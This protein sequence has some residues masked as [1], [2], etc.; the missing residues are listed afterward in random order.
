MRNLRNIVLASGGVILVTV[1]IIIAVI[2]WLNWDRYRSDAAHWIESVT[3]RPVSIDG[4]MDVKLFPSPHLYLAGVSIGNSDDNFTDEPE[5][6][7]EM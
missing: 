4:L 5:D 2:Q 7:G 6:E 1:A 3:A